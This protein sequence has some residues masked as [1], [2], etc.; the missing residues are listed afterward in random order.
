[1]VAGSVKEF[2]PRVDRESVEGALRAL[3]PAVEP[4]EGDVVRVAIEIPCGCSGGA[5]EERLELLRP[6]KDDVVAAVPVER[7]LLQGVVVAAVAAQANL[8]GVEVAGEH[9][10]VAHAAVGRVAAVAHVNVLVALV[11]GDAAVDDLLVSVDEVAGDPLRD[12]HRSD[13]MVVQEV[14]ADRLV[15][16]GKGE[17]LVRLVARMHAGRERESTCMRVSPRR[18]R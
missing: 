4:R 12:A 3:R 2:Y 7:V 16:K 18:S 10:E 8:P 9:L 5:R 14:D 17:A 6:D 13:P 11:G 1:M 15:L